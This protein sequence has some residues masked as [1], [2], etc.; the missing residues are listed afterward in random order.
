[1]KNQEQIISMLD[2]IAGSIGTIPPIY[3]SF[4]ETLR[5]CF[6]DPQIEPGIGI[7]FKTK[8][9]G[10]RHVEPIKRGT[11]PSDMAAI[12]LTALQM[13]VGSGA[14]PLGVV[15]QGIYHPGTSSGDRS[16]VFYVRAFDATH[17]F[18]AEWIGNGILP[19]PIYQA[20]PATFV[21]WFKV[22]HEA[23]NH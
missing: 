23:T 19:K 14:I 2:I 8:K 10:G 13:V 7:A 20:T 6:G 5:N 1:M 22:E 11:S 16:P 15:S 4:R 21:E 17:F 3:K 18:S 9:G 12:E